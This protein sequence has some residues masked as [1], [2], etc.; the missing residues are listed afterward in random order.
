M[1]VRIPPETGAADRKWVILFDVVLGEGSHKSP[2]NLF[3]PFK[4][5]KENE[6]EFVATIIGTDEDPRAIQSQMEQL[7]DGCDSLSPLKL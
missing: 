5:K 6:L 2:V 1:A 3:L 4:S 7:N